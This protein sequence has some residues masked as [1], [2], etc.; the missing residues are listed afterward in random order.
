MC[1]GVYVLSEVKIFKSWNF[2][3][4]VYN[5]EINKEDFGIYDLMAFWRLIFRFFNLLNMFILCKGYLVFL[6][7]IIKDLRG[8][9]IGRIEEWRSR[10]S[11]IV[12]FNYY[13]I[14]CRII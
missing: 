12:E 2:I 6:K 13:S 9:I 14:N 5:K 10:E 4:Y 11:G 1:D 3:V 8:E 7:K